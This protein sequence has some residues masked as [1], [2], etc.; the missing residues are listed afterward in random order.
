MRGTKNKQ[1]FEKFA[2][3]TRSFPIVSNERFNSAVGHFKEASA[4]DPDYARPKGWLAYTY[5]LSLQEGWTFDGAQHPEEADWSKDPA[6]LGQKAEAL[7]QAAKAVD[8]TDYDLWWALAV[9]QLHTKSPS[10]AIATYETALELNKDENNPHLLVE[11]A[12]ALLLA[13]QHDRALSLCRKA[14][15][16]RDWHRH[17]MAFCYYVKARK[18]PKPSD[19]NEAPTIPIFY[20]LCLEELRCLYWVPDEED[21][22]ST[23]QLLAAAAHAQ[24]AKALEREGKT[25]EC[26]K[27]Q[28]CAERALSVFKTR[29]EFAGFTLAQACARTPFED[30][31]DM[32]HW[33]EG[34][35]LAGL[36]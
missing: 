4:L 15:R 36:K 3:G 18:S 9:V 11:M 28:A 17:Q 21:Y 7:A 27:E 35:R 13:G 2:E 24:K 5:V 19:P 12:D 6:V 16:V 1:A 34:C 31:D 20:D 25:K 30:P 33:E 32:A 14:R 23:T 8:D 22:V 29:P 26:E 10:Q